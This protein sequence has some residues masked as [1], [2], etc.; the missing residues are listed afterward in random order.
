MISQNHI[1]MDP[2]KIRV[3]KEWPVPKNDKE[4]S[5]F[6]GFCTY[7]R[8]FINRFAHILIPLYKLLRHETKFIWN[9]ECQSAFQNMKDNMISYS[10]FGNPNFN[11]KFIVTCDASGHAIGVI[12]SQLDS[13][14][15]EYVCAYTSRIL[16]NAEI[17]YTIT[18]KECLAVIY[19]IK[20]YH[21]YLSGR[22]FRIITD[23]IALKWLMNIKEPSS[24]LARWAIYIQEYDFEIVHRAG[25]YLI[26]AD[27]IS[28]IPS[29]QINYVTRSKTNKD[30]ELT[31]KTTTDFMQ[32][33]EQENEN[34]LDPWEN[35]TLIKFVQTGI[36]PEKV[37][38]SLQNKIIH[39]SQKLGWENNKLYYFP[40]KNNFN[41]KSNN[42]LEIPHPDDRSLIIADTH[43]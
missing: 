28:R 7:Y 20:T 43:N 1:E 41:N 37:S 25:R 26:N 31:T 24:R 40:I 21:I 19:A 42:K 3:V 6:I 2:E 14:Q 38:K 30:K 17:N 5:R 11:F 35:P 9:H 18:E 29:E 36:F 13:H 23:H 32:E 22:H 39:Q 15:H 34:S 16:K 33:T 27:A 12:L 8:R 10:V 4:L